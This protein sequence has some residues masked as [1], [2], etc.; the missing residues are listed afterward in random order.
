MNKFVISS[1]EEMFGS[2]FFESKEIAIEEGKI[3]YEGESF[4]V[5]E[6]VSPTK[7]ESIFSV[8]DWLEGVSCHTDYD[9]EWAEGWDTSTK[10]QRKEL[11]SEVQSIMGKW[12][13]KHDLRPSFFN[14][15]NVELVPHALTERL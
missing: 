1:D 8:D 4:W 7:P 2:T 13:D 3:E 11:E 12:L 15:V 10:E 14:V 9:V 5:G 6:A